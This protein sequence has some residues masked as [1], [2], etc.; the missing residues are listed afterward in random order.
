MVKKIPADNE[1]RLELE[2]LTI[3]FSDANLARLQFISNFH[4]NYFQNLVSFNHNNFEI[5]ILLERFSE[6][7]AGELITLDI[8]DLERLYVQFIAIYEI[9]KSLDLHFLD[10]GRFQLTPDLKVRFPSLLSTKMD[11]NSNLDSK[12]N[13]RDILKV[14]QNSEHFKDLHER[15][16]REKFTHLA[17][18]YKFNENQSYLYRFD[19]FAANI[20][21]SYPLNRSE[22]SAQTNIKVKIRTSH[23]IQKKII[24]NQ[25]RSSFSS[26]DVFFMAI[27]NEASN[28]RAS[29][30]E[31]FLKKSAKSA[32]FVKIFNELKIFLGKFSF[33]SLVLVIDH[34]KTR[35]DSNLIKYLLDSSGITNILLIVFDENDFIDFDL[36]LKE[37]A[38]NL[39]DKYLRFYHLEESEDLDEREI[40]ILKV[41]K[42]IPAPVSQKALT[43]VFSSDDS[44][45][46]DSLI[47]KKYLKN[48]SGEIGPQTK[49]SRLN[50]QLTRKEEKEILKLFLD[51][52]DSINL[53][54][55]YFINTGKTAELKKILKK[56]LQNRY[57]F[58][59]SYVSIRKIFFENLDFLEKEIELVRLFAD[60]FIKENDLHSARELI[61]YCR[62]HDSLYLDLKLAHVCKLEKDYQEMEHLLKTIEGQI[63]ADLKDEFYYLQFMY[64]EMTAGLKK[65]DQYLKK[66]NAPRYRCLADIQLSDR[67]IYRGKLDQAQSL[68]KETIAYLEHEKYFRDEI[69]AKNQLAKLFRQK[70]D[71]QEAENL[72]QNIF[73][74]SEISDYKLL[75]AHISIDLGNLY[76]SRE[77]FSRA[78]SWYKK[79]LKIYQEQKNQNGEIL[80]A[81]NLADICKIKGNWQETENYLKATL[82]YDKEKNKLHALAVDHFNIAQLEYLKHNQVKALEFVDTA[83]ALFE[84]KQ[85]LVNM[86]ECELFKSKISLLMGKQKP[87][88]DFLRKHSD[89]LNQDQ[90]IISSLLQDLDKGIQPDQ[91]PR[92]LEEIGE[93]Q[94]RIQR[95]EILS[96]L[97]RKYR[98]PE[99]LDQLRSLSMELS[100]GT[101]NYYYYEYYYIYFNH[102]LR[103]EEMDE[104][105]KEIFSHIYYFFLK[106][107][108]KI[109]AR[110][111][112]IKNLLD[113]RDSSYDVF[114]SAELV[115]DY[116]QWK[117]PEDLFKSLVNE[118]GKIVKVD[119]VK[120]VI[121][122]KGKP[123][124][125]FANVNKF[126]ELTEEILASAASSLENQNLKLEDVKNRYQSEEKVFYFFE[127]TKVMLWKI[128]ET[129][130]GIL[131]LAFVS[132]DYQDYDFYQRNQDLFKKFASLI[133]RY[134]EKDFKLHQKLDFLIGE[135]LAMKKIKE[136]ILKVSK[137]NFTLLI[138]GESGSG[139][140]LIAK[141]VHLMSERADK[142]FITV[143]SAA[144]PESLLEAELFG[145][146]KGAF[147]GA[148][149]DRLG[150]I[151]AAHQGTLFLDEIAD[152]PLNLQ[153]K[154]LRVLQEKEI[155]RL[156]ENKT[157]QVNFRL[158]AATNKNLRDMVKNNQFREDLFFRIQDLPLQVPPLR[159]R[160]EDIPLLVEH[161]LKKNNF[162]IKDKLEFQSIVEYLKNQEWPGNIRQLESSIKRLITYY[163]DF[164][165][166]QEVTFRTDFSLKA[167]RENLEK[168]LIKKTLKENNWNKIKTAR[169]LKI[170]RMYLFNL[171]KKY[172][173]TRD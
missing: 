30:A 13:L 92:M 137:V 75:S 14:F 21:H 127:S 65:A 19:D 106:N 60:I 20:L 71:Y 34:L 101:R 119:L 125:N 114:K 173:I 76:H 88:S 139:K 40:Y 134:Y 120:L 83:L 168:S 23:H 38:N 4:S 138:S 17:A 26:E 132:K 27:D 39:L 156:G 58:E 141:A 144:I 67:Y 63:P 44:E 86:I 33:K 51:K 90:R 47:K 48:V 124:F 59:D 22:S 41:F 69:E 96:L 52:F 151:E 109:S 93:I 64:H 94:S 135:S 18:R 149:E 130:F 111:N 113:E 3:P 81:S 2:E 97:I 6:S 136:E 61:Q 45:L 85:D 169:T 50:L 66:I 164:E 133:Q 36:E 170:S 12:S 77:D 104:S 154:L 98:N 91:L 108:R 103:P 46:I 43:K 31:I 28:L 82:K 73:I 142:P 32:D 107:K 143:N 158:I 102:F 62:Q 24:K 80:A 148:N 122:E 8:E 99:L 9:S 147:T 89:K 171:I 5:N 110:I 152:L 79:A 54:I 153:A 162:S 131:L 70:G 117:I 56:Y 49:L 100:R 84:K 123:L 15:N 128:S 1:S 155:R 37:R 42:A 160:L 16:Y 55:K 115:G 78:E 157:R 112:R 165:M 118:I 72:Y 116:I 161:F 121:Y 126:N 150:L 57:R 74:Q 129:L 166:G 53:M 10:L 172:N 11:T 95:F 25:L 146:K 87:S 68:L 145:Y 35:E 105:T 167:A 140:E 7:S 29:F 163:P 159:D